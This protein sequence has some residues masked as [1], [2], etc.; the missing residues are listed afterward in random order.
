MAL[1]ITLVLAVVKDDAEL[2]LANQDEHVASALPAFDPRCHRGA[3]A[4]GEL[5]EEAAAWT[6]NYFHDFGA[7]GSERRA[8]RFS[9]F[10]AFVARS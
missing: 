5:H 8:W 6:P 7:A 2:A 9:A 1:M 10:A 4:G 3:G